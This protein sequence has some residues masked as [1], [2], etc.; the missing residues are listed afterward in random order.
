MILHEL[1]HLAVAR[2]YNRR[3]GKFK[4]LPIGINLEIEDKSFK[5]L[6]N[7]TIYLAGP[8]INCILICIASLTLFLFKFSNAYYMT[9]FIICNLYLLI[10]NLLPAI[11]L[12]G[13]KIVCEVLKLKSGVNY[14]TKCINITTGFVVVVI[15]VISF[16]QFRNVY[17]NVNSFFISCYIISNLKSFN[18]EASTLNIKY[19][20]N[21]R[22]RFLKKG[23][24]PV[25]QL[26]VIETYKLI[27]VLK[28]LDFDSF[29]IVHVVDNNLKM[30]RSY[31]EQE[32]IDVLL[33]QDSNIDFRQLINNYQIN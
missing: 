28:N 26:V 9:F 13:G 15:G 25:R 14:S 23:I 33:K 4:V 7:I 12:D 21:R 32:I 18:M 17:V 8:I 1:G 19:I 6:E 16:F 5:A 29:H 11:P 2:H 31:T 3:V 22:M 30:L 20:I 10:L 24:Y 27:E